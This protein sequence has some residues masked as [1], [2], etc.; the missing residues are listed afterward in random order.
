MRAINCVFHRCGLR[1]IEKVPLAHVIGWELGPEVELS[2][3]KLANAN[4]ASTVR[5]DLHQ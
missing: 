1:A 2:L 4:A 5:S 3:S